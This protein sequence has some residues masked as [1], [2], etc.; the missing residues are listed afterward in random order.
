MSVNIAEMVKT[1]RDTIGMISK[2]TM[3]IAK[4]VSFLRKGK[5]KKSMRALGL[6]KEPK[7]KTASSRWLEMQYGWLPL[8]GDIH[9]LA[10]QP[11][12]DPL[13]KRSSSRT[14]SQTKNFTTGFNPFEGQ[15]SLFQETKVRFYATF[16]IDS[17]AISAGH[18]VGILNPALLAWESVPFSFVVDWFLPVGSYLESLTALKGVKIIQFGKSITNRSTCTSVYYM[19]KNSTYI[20]V[21][22][23][24]SISFARSKSRA[25]ESLSRPLPRFKNPLSLGHFANALALLRTSF[26]K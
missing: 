17:A 18:Q 19:P 5:V 10:S 13:I 22:S 23:G 6:T 9:T 21:D 8:M 26:K 3:Q 25:S 4:A 1:R 2:N 24:Q 16:Q 7:S 20:G 12:N 11:L 14:F 15:V